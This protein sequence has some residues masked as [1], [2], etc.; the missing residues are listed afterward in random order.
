MHSQIRQKRLNLRLGGK[1]ACAR[2]HVV[3][4]DEPHDPVHIGPLGMNGIVM[5]TEDVADFIEQFWLLT[6]CGVRPMRAPLKGC[7]NRAYRHRRLKLQ[8]TS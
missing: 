3:K 1:E 8:G 7:E 2:S 4:P 5:E 6:S